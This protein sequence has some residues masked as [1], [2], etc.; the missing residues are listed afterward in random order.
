MKE[1]ETRY[2]SKSVPVLLTDATAHWPA[3]KK[4]NLD[5]FEAKFNEKAVR[6]DNREW[7]VGDFVRELK[8][9]NR[10]V[11]PY[12]KM[13]KLD[14]QLPELWSDVG[15][16]A[17][18]RNNRLQSRLLPRSM[19]IMKGIVAVFVGTKGSGFRTLHWDY[20]YLHVFISQI[21]GDKDAVLFRPEDTPYLYPKPETENL[22]LLPDPFHVDLEK[23]PEFKHAQPI[24]ITIREGETLFLPG[25]WWHATYIGQPNVAIAESTLDRFNW[26][27]RKH[28]YLSR[29]RQAK[30][31]I[32]K[33]QL[34]NLY[35]SAVDKIMK[36]RGLLRDNG[37]ASVT[38][39]SPDAVTTLTDVT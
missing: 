36:L 2:A 38:V 7:K 37:Q 34:L 1:F 29:Y 8:A 18:A 24:R 33:R 5:Y 15:D 27:L 10:D 14:E 31:P 6:F 32:F 13:V 28:W 22:S 4:W 26:G 20:S 39:A 11:V 9:S 19:R 16:L 17:L 12:L 30:V 25:G 23:F 21:C 3:R 35:L